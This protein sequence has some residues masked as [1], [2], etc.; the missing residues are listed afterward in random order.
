MLQDIVLAHKML[1]KK[2]ITTVGVALIV[3]FMIS[4]GVDVIDNDEGYLPYTCDKEIVPDYMC[5]KLSRIGTTGV[6]RNC[7]YDRDAPRKYK[8]CST[9]WKKLINI[10]EYE[11]GCSKLVVA[12]TDYG[13]WFCDDIG[14]DANCVLED[15]LEMPF[16]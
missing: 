9:G 6:N 8:V 14:P 2:L 10:D 4:L 1:D 13:K 3:G 11:S 7:Y 12:Y 16:D 15:T 5:Y